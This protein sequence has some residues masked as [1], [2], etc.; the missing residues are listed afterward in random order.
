MNLQEKIVSWMKAKVRPVTF[1]EV[2]DFHSD[3]LASDIFEAML[4]LL[5]EKNKIFRV[6]IDEN[7]SGYK[8]TSKA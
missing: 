3:K 6:K 7:K 5:E 4:I 8:L 2:C 1:Q